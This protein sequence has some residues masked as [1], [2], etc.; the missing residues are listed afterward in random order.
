MIA[1]VTGVLGGGKSYYGARKISEALLK[2]KVVATNVELNTREKGFKQDWWKVILG[3][4]PHYRFASRKQKAFYE[5]EIRERYAYIP[6]VDVLVSAH[7]YGKGEGRGIRVLDEAHNN[8]NNR[9]WLSE[10]QKLILRKM[11]LARKRGWDD[12]IIA[13][14]KDNTDMALRRIAGVEIKLINWR[15]HLQLPVFHTKVLPFN[16]FLAQGFPMNAPSN[17]R[18]QSKP[19]WRELYLLSWPR[20]IYNTFEDFD[21][22]FS[23]EHTLDDVWLPIRGGYDHSE[24]IKERAARRAALSELQDEANALSENAAPSVP[25]EQLRS[26]LRGTPEPLLPASLPSPSD[27]TPNPPQEAPT[28]ESEDEAH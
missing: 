26:E 18:R 2:G 11:A 17:V 22:G 6:D 25:W 21:Y 10:N 24:F 1:Y 16:L 3:H 13:Q 8:L 19:I 14:H 27:R 15:Q 23:E 28:S 4:A 5:R 12:Y 20:L 9:E 7:L